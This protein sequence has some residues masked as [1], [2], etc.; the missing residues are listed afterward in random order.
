[1]DRI[2][3]QKYFKTVDIMDLSLNSKGPKS[4]DLLERVEKARNIQRKR[5][6]GIIGVCCNA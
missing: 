5:Y 4:K 6:N 3:I 1:M 2:D